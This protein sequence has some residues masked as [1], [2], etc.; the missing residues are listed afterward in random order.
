MKSPIEELHPAPTVGQIWECT[1]GRCH[2]ITDIV[3]VDDCPIK[4]TCYLPGPWEWSMDGRI[5]SG[6]PEM[7]N[8]LIRLVNEPHQPNQS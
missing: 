1:H 4:T 5:F 2:K 8:R 6:P 7:A 3:P